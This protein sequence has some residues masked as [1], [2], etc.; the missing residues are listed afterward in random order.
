[1]IKDSI[2]I[3][4]L[5]VEYHKVQAGKMELELKLYEKEED[6]HRIRENIQ[7]QKNR[8]EQLEEMIKDKKKEAKDG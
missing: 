1:M 4:R 7:I 2:E 8:M 3:K 5:Q 6:M